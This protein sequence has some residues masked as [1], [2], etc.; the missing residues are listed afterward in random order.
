MPH[1]AVF[2]GGADLTQVSG[3]AVEDRAF[4]GVELNNHGTPF[5]GAAADVASLVAG[6]SSNS[7]DPGQLISEALA[8]PVH[9]LLGDVVGLVAVGQVGL[10]GADR[11]LSGHQEGLTGSDGV[12]A[13]QGAGHL[14]QHQ[15]VGFGVDVVGFNGSGSAGQAVA[16]DQEIDLA[17]PLGDLAGGLHPVL[18][19][20]SADE[21][22]QAQHEGQD[23]REELLHRKIPSFLLRYPFSFGYSITLYQKNKNNTRPETDFSLYTLQRL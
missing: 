23:Q 21:H 11:L 5:Q 17:I 13:S 12:A 14:L 8:Q 10:Q 3:A 20:R 9:V 16:N 6:R 18:F 15:D 22:G 4:E 1:A 19:G 7:L 2:E